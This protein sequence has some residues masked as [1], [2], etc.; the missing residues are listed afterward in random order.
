LLSAVSRD[1]E[2]LQKLCH[3]LEATYSMKSMSGIGS[4]REMTLWERKITQVVEEAHA[5]QHSLDRCSA[6]VQ[7]NRREEAQR[8]E[9]LQRRKHI[10]AGIGDPESNIDADLQAKERIR[11]SKQVAEEAYQTGVS[12]LAAMATQR[13]LLKSAHRKVLDVLN[14]VGMSDSVLRIAERRISVDKMIAYGG[15]AV[16]TLVIIVWLYVTGHTKT[17]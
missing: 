5:L 2:Q 12:A 3:D 4:G 17:E 11:R 1:T 10:G 16:I 7:Q 9:L 13:D 15:M 8:Q 6:H 14:T